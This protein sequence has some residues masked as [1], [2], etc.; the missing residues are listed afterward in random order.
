MSTKSLLCFFFC[1]P[2]KVAIKPKSDKCIC[3]RLVSEAIRFPRLYRE[4][5]LHWLV[6]YSRR[7]LSNA[8]PGEFRATSSHREGRVALP[9]PPSPIYTVT[10]SGVSAASGLLGKPGTY[11]KSPGIWDLRNSLPKTEKYS[12]QAHYISGVAKFCVQKIKHRT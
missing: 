5:Q 3:L 11:Q 10:H 7:D 12:D 4:R 1:V 8:D 9:P 6:Q 2:E